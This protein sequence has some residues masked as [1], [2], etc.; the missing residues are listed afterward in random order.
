MSNRKAAEDFIIS[1]IDKL[2]PGSENVDIYRKLFKNM[3]DEQFSDFMLK[4]E[5]KENRLAIIAPNFGKSKLNVERNLKIA[6]ELGHNFFQRIWIDGV[7]ERPKYLTPIPYMVIDLPLRRQAQLLI[8]KISIPDDNKTVDNLTGQPTGS[9]K[10]S[11]ISYP[12]IQVLAAMN[13][14]NSLL[15]L[16]K[17]RGGD[18][19]GFIAMN[20]MISIRGG[21]SLTAIERFAGGVESTKTLKS[22]LTGMHLSNTL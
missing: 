10:G 4:L 13:L 14:D 17:F 21:V 1:Y 7:G 5:N 9:S 15:E 16:L 2:L 18:T 19:K 11:K 6:D 12:E 8:K 20:K 22:L 3:T